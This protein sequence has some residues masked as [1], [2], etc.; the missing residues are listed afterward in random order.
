MAD[1]QKSK[2]FWNRV[3]A[4]FEAD[5]FPEDV[6]RAV[7][8]LFLIIP[9]PQIKQRFLLEFCR[10]LEVAVRRGMPLDEA[11]EAMSK[12]RGIFSRR[13]VLRDLAG[14]VRQGMPLWVA[15]SH[16]SWIF[17]KYFC[18]MLRIGRQ[19]GGLPET[20]RTLYEFY[21][22]RQEFQYRFASIFIYPALLLL[23]SLFYYYVLFGLVF[24]RFEYLYSSLLDNAP[25]PAL[26]RWMISFVYL[27]KE[28]LPAVLLVGFLL[29]LFLFFGNVVEPFRSLR[30]ILLGRLPVVRS[31]YRSSH[32]GRFFHALHFLLKKNFQAPQALEMTAELF[33]RG[34][35]RQACLA[36]Q[37]E[38]ARGISLSEALQEQNL[39]EEREL[40]QLRAGEMKGQVPE[41]LAELARG[42]EER[43]SRT[44]DYIQSLEPLVY[45]PVGIFNALVIAAFYLMI[46]NICSTMLKLTY[47]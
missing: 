42:I 41:A 15:C 39:L 44:M 31:L 45:L 34:R 4:V 43:K 40:W 9:G 7:D 35:I 5:L 21:K 8:N 46:F 11:L 18:E 23:A 2:G 33:P 38:M 16:Y 6:R 3:K 22:L 20:F 37:D 36:L 14:K 24:P 13:R 25:F 27:L 17:P 29:F 1:G 12:S 28:S 47:F 10:Y 19:G 26:A 30:E 32:H